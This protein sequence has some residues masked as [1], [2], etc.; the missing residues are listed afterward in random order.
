M[1]ALGAISRGVVSGQ[2]GRFRRGLLGE[3]E[4]DDRARERA[5]W[6]MQ[7]IAMKRL[8]HEIKPPRWAKERGHLGL[9]AKVDTARCFDLVGVPSPASH[10]FGEHAQGKRH[11]F[12]IA[13]F[14]REH[15][16]N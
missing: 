5:G 16:E 1:G 15:A 9:P 6:S 13:K 12:W 8:R 7:S 3:R 11:E 4:A 2:S 14:L 10:R